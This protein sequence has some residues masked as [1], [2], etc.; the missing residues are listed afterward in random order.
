MPLLNY[1][2][3]SW[4]KSLN[5]AF[6]EWDILPYG[7]F[8]WDFDQSLSQPENHSGHCC[9]FGDCLHCTE[10]FLNCSAENDKDVYQWVRLEVQ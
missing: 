9:C 4:S 7:V 8:F 3:N 1:P 2:K 6:I 5:Q 10:P